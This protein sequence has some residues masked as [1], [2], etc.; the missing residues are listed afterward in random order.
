MRLV[1]SNKSSC[2]E[3]LW[4][5]KKKMDFFLFLWVWNVRIWLWVMDLK[6]YVWMS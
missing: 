4:I 5:N 1:K 2:L 6:G 3:S